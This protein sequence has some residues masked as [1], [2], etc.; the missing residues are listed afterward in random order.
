M[1][2]FAITLV[3]VLMMGGSA[4]ATSLFDEDGCNLFTSDIA[5]EIG[6]LVTVLVT[7]SVSASNRA[8]TETEKGLTTDG[9]LSVEGFLQW[10]ADLPP[11]ITP[12]EDLTFTPTE[13][14][15]GEGRVQ[16]S[17]T[18]T[19][20]IT[21]VVTDMLPNGNLVVEGVRT[22]TIAEDTAVLTIRGIVDPNDITL[23]NTVASSQVAD[24]E[25]QYEG[26]GIIAERQHDG[27]L[28]RI[29]NFFF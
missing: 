10:V 6:D 18:F 7:E 27:I 9:Q 26:E 28:S 19:A 12:I 23:D 24:L 22:I 4:S 5:T 11:T 17:G 2:I 8:T 25:I 20:R 16:T 29:F 21:A 3:L 14:F 1:R 15:S 13:E